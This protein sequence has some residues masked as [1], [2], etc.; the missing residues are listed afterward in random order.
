[1]ADVL[2]I[3]KVPELP[4]TLVPDSLYFTLTEDA[5]AFNLFMT[6]MAGTRAVPLNIP[7]SEEGV[8][9]FMLMGVGLDG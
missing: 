6:D 5:Q 7:A 2:K 1:M 9:Q 3:Y 8:D 4:Q